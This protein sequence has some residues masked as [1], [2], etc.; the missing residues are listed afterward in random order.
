MAMATLRVAQELR[1]DVPSQLSVIGFANFSMSD[2]AS[3]ALT[4]IEQPFIEIGRAAVNMLLDLIHER[5]EE[6][7]NRAHPAVGAV[8]SGESEAGPQGA[9]NKNPVQ[10]IKLLPTRLI[11]RESVAAPSVGAANA[12]RFSGHRRL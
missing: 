4:T 3:P 1:I 5:E 8:A 11:E 7:I 2:Y 6:H 9:G 10:R 12:G